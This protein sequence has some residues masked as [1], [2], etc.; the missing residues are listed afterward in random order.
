M[1]EANNLY[2]RPLTVDDL[3]QLFSYWLENREYLEPFQP[4]LPESFYTKEEQLASIK[5]EMYNWDNDRSYSFGIFDKHHQLIGKSSLTHIVRAAWQNCVLGYSIAEKMQG[6][7]YMTEAV[8]LTTQ[9]AF[10]TAKLHRVQAG[11][12]P[13]NKGSIRVLEKNGFLYEGLSKYHVKIN[14]TWEDHK[15]FSITKE[16]WDQLTH[17]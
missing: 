15:M 13:R 1:L 4:L 12:M 10:E 2:I 14:G 7:G 17:K 16:T 11:V 3:D 5:M 6:K 9:F 8:R